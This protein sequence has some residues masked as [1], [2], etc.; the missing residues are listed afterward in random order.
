MEILFLIGISG[1]GKSTF[2]EEFFLKN[3]N[4]LCINRDYIRKTL[5]KNLDGYYKRQDLN[6]LENIVSSISYNIIKEAINYGYNLII[7]NTNL[8]WNY[9][10]QTINDVGIY[11]QKIS[12]KLFDCNPT[13]AKG[14]ILRRDYN[15]YMAGFEI[16]EHVIKNVKY[17]EKQYEQYQ[18]IKK[19]ILENYKEN[20]L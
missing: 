4:Y 20:I 5:V 3:K 14:R 18:H 6:E 17:I 10:K 13:I 16:P 12:F 11:K 19:Y 1:S 7:D 15:D 2:A 9:I 8:N